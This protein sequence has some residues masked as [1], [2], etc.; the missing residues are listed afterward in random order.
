MNI[1]SVVTSLAIACMAT[2]TFAGDCKDCNTKKSLDEA[3][4]NPMVVVD[5]HAEAWCG[6][7]RTMG[8]IVKKV[9]QKFDNVKFFK[10][11]IDEFD[12]P[13]ITGVP[14][15]VFYKNGKEIKRFS[16]TRKEAEFINE[17]NKAFGL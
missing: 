4:K 5:F 3:I 11:N 7:C 15:F 6:P 2:V 8:P 1:K 17:V 16:G 9:A 10:C 13:G 12:V 14:T